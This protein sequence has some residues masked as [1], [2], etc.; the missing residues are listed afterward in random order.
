MGSGQGG[1][2]NV[3]TGFEPEATTA[4]PVCSRT[5]GSWWPTAE[6]RLDGV[7]KSTLLARV[8]KKHLVGRNPPLRAIAYCLDV[9]GIGIDD[10][11]SC[12]RRQ[13][14]RA[15]D[16]LASL[17][18]VLPIRDKSK[19]RALPHP[20]HHLAH[21]YSA[22]FCSPFAESAVLVADVFGSATDNGTETESGFHARENDISPVFKNFQKPYSPELP[23]AQISY[24]LTYIYNFVSLALCFTHDGD[25]PKKGGVVAEAGKT[26]GL[27]SYGRPTRKPRSGSSASSATEWIRAASRNGRWSNRI[28][29]DHRRM[30]WFRSPKIRARRS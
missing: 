14:R 28:G 17:R 19:I 10:P 22:F 20:S 29:Q 21:A 12:H 4:V 6:E 8:G 16:G 9:E 1:T 24:G 3:H 13:R 26:M 2:T 5:A 7:K 23:E 18:S 25:K 27:A 11:R 15:G 30:N